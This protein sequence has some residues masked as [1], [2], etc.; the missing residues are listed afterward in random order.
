[1]RHLGKPYHIPIFLYIGGGV[2]VVKP[3]KC[4]CESCVT[5]AMYIG[6]QSFFSCVPHLDLDGLS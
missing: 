5:F 6:W 3:W 4:V 2:H 1:M